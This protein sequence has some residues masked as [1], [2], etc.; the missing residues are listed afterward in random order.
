MYIYI[1]TWVKCYVSNHYLNMIDLKKVRMETRSVFVILSIFWRQ[2]SHI[3]SVKE[4][5]HNETSFDQQTATST[6]EFWYDHTVWYQK[7]FGIQHVSFVAWNIIHV[8]P[9]LT[10]SLRFMQ[11]HVIVDR[12]NS[13]PVCISQSGGFRESLVKTPLTL[14]HGWIII[15]QCFMWV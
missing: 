8:G 13:R 7:L 11:W 15:F 14:M 10:Q 1:Y 12:D 4:M 3:S 9:E 2:E 5:Y 6:K